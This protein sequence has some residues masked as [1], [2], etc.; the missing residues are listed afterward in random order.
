LPFLIRSL[1]NM[2]QVELL[3][4]TWP[5]VLALGHSY[6]SSMP[7]SAM[8]QP[9]L[10]G[11]SRILHESCSIATLDRA[12]IV[13][14]ARANV[15]RIMSIDL[16]VGSRLPAFC[17]SKGRVLMADLP[18][19]KLDEFLARVE[20]RRHTERTVPN[21]E[22]LR[23]I[24]RFVQHNGYCIVDQE[25]ESGL[26]SMAVPI[27]DSAG[28]VVASLN[29]GAHAQ[30]VSIQDMQVRFLPHLKAAAQELCLIVR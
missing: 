5:R 20:F 14:I 26:R 22:K 11:V 8:T 25:L 13:C 24:L 2:P 21:A 1:G 18:A 19:E 4:N 30:R 7:L 27:R 28:R 17:T 3:P 29:V 12:D 16:V 10:E 6:I 15:T 9:I 23:Q